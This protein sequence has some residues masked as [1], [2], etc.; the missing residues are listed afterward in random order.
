MPYTDTISVDEF[1]QKQI[2]DKDIKK[3]K[4]GW[5]LVDGPSTRSRGRLSGSISR[6]IRGDFGEI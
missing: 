4:D 1:Y 3:T 2:E 6:F 5:T